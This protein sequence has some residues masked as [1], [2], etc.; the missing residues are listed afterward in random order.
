LSG[1]DGGGGDDEVGFVLAAGVVEDDEEL[2]VAWGGKSVRLV[3][4]ES[5]RRLGPDLGGLGIPCDSGME[6][7]GMR[8]WRGRMEGQTHGRH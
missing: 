4:L 8:P 2:A 5:I 7:D 3:V 1:C 6:C